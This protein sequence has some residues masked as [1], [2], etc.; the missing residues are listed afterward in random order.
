MFCMTKYTLK[1]SGYG[2]Y[3]HSMKVMEISDTK[4][5]KLESEG[6]EIFNSKE[7]ALNKMRESDNG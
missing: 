2:K 7:Q 3:K 6:K 4:A 1:G 5:M